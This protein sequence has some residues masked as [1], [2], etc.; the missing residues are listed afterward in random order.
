MYAIACCLKLMDTHKVGRA[1]NKMKK[2]QMKN[3][4]K[5]LCQDKNIDVVLNYESSSLNS[6]HSYE[7]IVSYCCEA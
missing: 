4:C 5:L 3:L 2:N 7:K 1:N 6:A